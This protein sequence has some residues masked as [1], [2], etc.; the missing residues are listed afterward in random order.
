MINRL[1][2][3]EVNYLLQNGNGYLKAAALVYLRYL[4][5][6]TQ[7]FLWLQ[8]FLNDF[9]ELQLSKEKGSKGTIAE[10]TKL[11]LTE[12]DYWGTRL[13]RIPMHIERDIKSEILKM[14]EQRAKTWQALR[15]VSDASDLRLRAI[16]RQDGRMHDARLV[17]LERNKIVVEFL[18]GSDLA[19]TAE[20]RLLSRDCG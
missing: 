19:N 6:P 11:L 4:L 7:L 15:N 2:E 10:L 14:E 13:T 5:V 18:D 12:Y 9:T 3:G 8:P 16:S 1:S 20:G 17:K